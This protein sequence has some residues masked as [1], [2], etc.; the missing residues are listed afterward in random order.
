M[1]GVRI[2]D[3]YAHHPVEIGAVLQAARALCGEGGKVFAVCQPHRYSRVLALIRDFQTCFGEADH[4][5]MLPIYSAGEAPNGVTS[6]DLIPSAC[7]KTHL[8][9]GSD[10]VLRYLAS[11]LKRG[12]MVVYLGAGDVTHLAARCPE[13]LARIWG[14]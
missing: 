3:D 11:H 2:V 6:G 5:L 7:P 4:V 9:S 14:A 13:E 12:D 10:D 8:V 1:Q